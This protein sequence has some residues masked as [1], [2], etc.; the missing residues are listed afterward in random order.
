M[1][2]RKAVNYQKDIKRDIY[3][4]HC[5][6]TFNTVQSVIAQQNQGPEHKLKNIS[7]EQG[8]LDKNLPELFHARQ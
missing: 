7:I 5:N 6:I 8:F 4:L 2:F 3:T 1:S